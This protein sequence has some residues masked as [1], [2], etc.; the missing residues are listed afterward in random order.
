M[1]EYSTTLS[2]SIE[3]NV[4]GIKFYEGYL[5][6]KPLQ[7]VELVREF[8]NPHDRSA[9]AVRLLLP[10]GSVMLGHLEQHVAAVI[11]SLMDENAA[12][13]RISRFVLYC[14]IIKCTYTILLS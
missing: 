11:S 2:C 1:V 4:M 3:A 8:R 6:L 10:H 13:L 5:H 9:V 14:I 7:R 12:E